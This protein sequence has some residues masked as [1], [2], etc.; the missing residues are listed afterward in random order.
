MHDA[1]AHVL[2]HG[3]SAV[4]S[5][6]ASSEFL[7]NLGD[8]SFLHASSVSSA[9]ASLSAASRPVHLTLLLSSYGARKFLPSRRSFLSFFFCAIGL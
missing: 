8:S 4:F 1:H 2:Q 3:H 5:D 9:I 6:G 7:C